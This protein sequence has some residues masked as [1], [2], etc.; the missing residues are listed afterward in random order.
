[1]DALFRRLF[2]GFDRIIGPFLRIELI[3]LSDQR[4]NILALCDSGDK[5]GAN[6]RGDGEN[7]HGPMIEAEWPFARRRKQVRGSSAESR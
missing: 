1:M 2:Q 3:G 4:R 7:S 5:N 6:R